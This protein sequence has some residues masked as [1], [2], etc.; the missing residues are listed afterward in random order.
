M[1]KALVLSGED[2]EKKI[3]LNS[4]EILAKEPRKTTGEVDQIYMSILD[5][6]QQAR[7]KRFLHIFVSKKVKE[8][9]GH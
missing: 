2:D 7:L 1:F 9:I 8:L 4:I 5:L 6:Q 3:H